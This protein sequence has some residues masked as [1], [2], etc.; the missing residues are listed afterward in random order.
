MPQAGNEDRWPP[1]SEL[2]NL[3]ILV[4]AFRAG[5]AV[6]KVPSLI[7]KLVPG[8]LTEPLHIAGY[9]LQG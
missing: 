7:T 3:A 5:W 1:I 9:C 8:R 2:S 6:G 4:N